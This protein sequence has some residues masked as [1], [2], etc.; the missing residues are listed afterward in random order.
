MGM[1]EL[2]K[3]EENI[4][5]IVLRGLTGNSTYPQLIIEGSVIG[6]YENIAEYYS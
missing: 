3:N 1:A 6:G 5:A 4:N 2:S